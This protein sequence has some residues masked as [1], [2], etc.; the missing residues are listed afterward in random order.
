M[1][2]KMKNI[3]TAFRHVKRFTMIVV[4][5]SFLLCCAMMFKSY[6]IESITQSKVYVLADGKVFEAIAGDR[7]DN[8]PVEAKDHIRTF[9][10]LFFTLDPDGKA[11]EA[12][13]GKALGMADATA[14]KQYQD[15]KENGFYAGI[16]SGNVSQR[17]IVDSIE[18]N[19]QSQ[20]YYFRCHATE[21]IIR[22]SS[23][24]YRSLVTEGYLRDV[25]R[26]ENNPHGFLIERWSIVENKDLKSP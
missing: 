2:R 5:G 16:I 13:I 15:L 18:L 21:T 19:L 9:H 8:I 26:S 12:G 7:K 20:P 1:F 4:A 25:S 3:D 11:N 22:S 23:T 24:L 14:K 10:Q 17:I 6:K